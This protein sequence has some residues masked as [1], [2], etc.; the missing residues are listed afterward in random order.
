MIARS[1]E[2]I[3][4]NWGEWDLSTPLVSVSCCTYN[5]EQYISEALD[6]FIM[7]K[8]NFPFEVIVHDDASTDKTADI[9]REYEEKYPLII[10]PIYETENQYSKHDGSIGKILQKVRKGKYIAICEGDDYWID[11]NKLQMQVDFLENNPDYGLVYTS[12][13]QYLQVENKVIMTVGVETSFDKLVKETNYIQNL[14]TCYRSDLLQKYL[15]DIKPETQGWLMG[16]YPQWIYFSYYKKIKFLPVVTCV[17]RILSN[18]ASHFTDIDKWIRFR[19]SVY[20]IKKFYQDYFNIKTDLIWDES[21]YYVPMHF[22]KGHRKALKNYKLSV[23]G[24]KNQIK[25]K[26][27]KCPFCFYLIWVLV[28]IKNFIMLV[29]R[30]IYYLLRGKNA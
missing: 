17:Y 10:K 8:T 13:Y 21:I 1:Q 27:A 26:L 18:S 19:K 14:T 20:D 7:Q 23:T 12:A 15:E 6:G 16:D 29:L 25:V 24:R 4:L 22:N 5:Q 2:E 3:M 30:K 9:I 11:E 28:K